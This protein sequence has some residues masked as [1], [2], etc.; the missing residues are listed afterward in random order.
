MVKRSRSGRHKLGVSLYPG[1]LVTGPV[2]VARLEGG[3]TMSFMDDRYSSVG[4]GV[5]GL[6]LVADCGV[7]AVVV[8]DVADCL[9]P[10]VREPHGVASP[11]HPAVAPL[12]RP[13]VV[14]AAV[15]VIH[16]KIVGIRLWLIVLFNKFWMMR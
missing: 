9:D 3:W 14:H 2:P 7:E 11:G 15:L 12:L 4:L 5:A 8:R 13:V 16:A 10:A 6:A 1:H